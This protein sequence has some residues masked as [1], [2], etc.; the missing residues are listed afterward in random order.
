ME[1]PWKPKHTVRHHNCIGL[2]GPVWEN[3][4]YPPV[5]LRP[6]LEV[7]YQLSQQ[8]DTFERALIEL[9]KVNKNSTAAYELREPTIEDFEKVSMAHRYNMLKVTAPAMKMVTFYHFEIKPKSATE[10][11]FNSHRSVGVWLH[12]DRPFVLNGYKLEPRDQD[13]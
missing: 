13:Q 6:K 4:K 1:V 2:P 3:F 11:I 5:H 10:M 8:G 12:P 7:I 9:E